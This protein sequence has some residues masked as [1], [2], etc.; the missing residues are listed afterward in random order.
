M[1]RSPKRSEEAS[2]TLG[3]GLPK[4][5]DHHVGAGR[6]QVLCSQHS[7]LQSHVS[8]L[9]KAISSLTSTDGQSVSV[10]W[11]PIGRSQCTAAD[12]E[13]VVVNGKDHRTQS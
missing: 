3:L 11:G 6:T 4:V 10:L 2:D 8:R 13:A 5:V 1:C 7:Q 12:N 9:E